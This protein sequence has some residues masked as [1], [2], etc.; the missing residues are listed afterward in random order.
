[1]QHILKNFITNPVN[2][3]NKFYILYNK[4]LYIPKKIFINKK[5]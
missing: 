5:Q 2:Y 3:K 1:M 4:I